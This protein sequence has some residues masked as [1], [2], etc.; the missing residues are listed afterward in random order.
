LAPHLFVDISAHGF[1]H[2]AQTAPVLN[3]LRARQPELMLTIRCG[4]PRERLAL[5]IAGTFEHIPHASDFGLVMNSAVEVDVAASLTLYQEFHAHWSERVDEYAQQLS[6]HQPDIV[7]ANISYLAL[8]AAHQT[9]IPAL[10]MCSLNWAEIFYPYC[11]EAH[12]A[13]ASRAQMLAAYNSAEAFLRLNPGMAMPGIDHLIEI[14]P[15]ARCGENVRPMLDALLGLEPETRLVLVA[16]GGIPMRL[17]PTGWPVL[18][19]YKWIVQCDAGLQRADIIP[20]ESIALDFSQIMASCDCIVTKSGYGTFVE[21]ATSGTPVLYIE[22][23]DW[24]EEPCLVAWLTQHNVAMGITRHQF[25][26]GEFA[27]ALRTLTMQPRAMPIFP[28]GIAQAADY[29]CQRVEKFR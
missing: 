8:A 9:G 29:L 20:L 13:M 19:G 14:G 17:S 18:P 23:P 26:R 1:G 7:L 6:Q 10:A 12:E 22:R 21:A 24:P 16:M 3:A 5:C 28:T 2:L 4:L 15:I 11:A 27:H 25:E